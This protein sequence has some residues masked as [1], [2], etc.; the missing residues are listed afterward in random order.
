MWD[1]GQLWE[2]VGSTLR[3]VWDSRPWTCTRPS[4]YDRSPEHHYTCFRNILRFV[5]QSRNP[6]S[7]KREGKP[8]HG[9]IF[10]DRIGTRL[11]GSAGPGVSYEDRRMGR[12][13]SGG[14]STGLRHSLC[15]AQYGLDFR[16]EVV[17]T[18]LVLF[19]L[20]LGVPLRRRDKSQRRV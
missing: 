2:K 3:R 9:F 20:T 8:P 13:W 17:D 1:S 18:P 4:V 7:Q 16:V 6:L 5:Y 14:V 10:I 12:E 15:F 11:S 19:R